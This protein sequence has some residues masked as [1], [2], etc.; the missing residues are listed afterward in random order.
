MMHGPEKAFAMLRLYQNCQ[1][2][3][4][5]KRRA[6]RAG[7]TLKQIHKF[8][9]L[10]E[11]VQLKESKNE[12]GKTRKVDDPW[13][14]F[15]GYGALQDWEW[16]VLKHYQSPE[17]EKENP[18]ARVFCAVKSPMTYGDWEYGD[19]YCHDIPGYKYDM[20]K[21]ENG[22]G[23]STKTIK[24]VKLMNALGADRLDDETTEKIMD[25][26]EDELDDYLDEFAFL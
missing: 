3:D 1:T 26:S 25:M 18:Y 9:T 8:L 20:G 7:Y 11:S 22:Q 5:F 10:Q 14:I 17:K 24:V 19:V 15:H 16:R 21:N 2:D 6:H 13:E 12:K 23:L 4:E